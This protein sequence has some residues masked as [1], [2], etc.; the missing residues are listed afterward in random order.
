MIVRLLV[1]GVNV[2]FAMLVKMD[3]LFRAKFRTK[4]LLSVL[5]MMSRVETHV[6]AE[7][8]GKSYHGGDRE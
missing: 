2:A 4:P 8:A 6:D 7:R 3:D 1:R 5:L